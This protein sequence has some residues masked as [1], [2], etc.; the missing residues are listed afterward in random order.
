MTVKQENLNS[1]LRPCGWGNSE[2]IYAWAQNAPELKLPEDVAFRVR[3]N[4]K[5]FYFEKKLYESPRVLLLKNGALL[6]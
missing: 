1:A 2:I 6:A 5:A 4:V 3:I